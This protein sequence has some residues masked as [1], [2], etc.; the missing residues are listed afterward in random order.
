MQDS[1]AQDQ[2]FMVLFVLKSPQ[3]GITWPCIKEQ[4]VLC[5]ASRVNRLGQSDPEQGEKQSEICFATTNLSVISL[6]Q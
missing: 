6:S 1:P 3:S 5:K 2:F 4:H